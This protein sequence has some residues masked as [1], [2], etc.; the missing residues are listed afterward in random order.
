VADRVQH[1]EV[2]ATTL[3][4][5]EAVAL[6]AIDVDV[7]DD[8]RL[9]VG[10]WPFRSPVVAAR[11]FECFAPV[12]AAASRSDTSTPAAPRRGARAT[13]L[14]ENRFPDRCGPEGVLEQ[15]A[16]AVAL[17]Y[18]SAGGRRS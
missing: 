8:E 14:A 5:G 11:A 10:S 3:V 6:E 9:A 12:G 13:Q 17:L 2:L 4:L 18:S 15:R 7:V 16:L 1:A